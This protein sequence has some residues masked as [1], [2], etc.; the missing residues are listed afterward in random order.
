MLIRHKALSNCFQLDV[1]ELNSPVC[2]IY[3]NNE[4]SEREIKETIPFTIP[5]K[6]IKYLG[7]NL[8]K[9]AKDQYSANCKI[10]MKEIKSDTADGK[11]YPVLGLEESIW[12]K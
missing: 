3:T 7:I 12:S 2:S 5:P 6:R 9:E 1:M 4:R 11:M 10:L 8:P